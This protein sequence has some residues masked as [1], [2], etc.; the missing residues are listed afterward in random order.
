VWDFLLT[1]KTE[2]FSIIFVVFE[3]I[4]G[5]C[6]PEKRMKMLEKESFRAKPGNPGHAFNCT[7]FASLS[8]S[9]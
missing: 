3:R 9:K 4:M 8:K 1:A 2:V 7:E 6:K 5:C